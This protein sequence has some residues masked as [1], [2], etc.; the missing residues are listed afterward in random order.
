MEEGDP[1]I[2]DADGRGELQEAGEPPFV[3]G[4]D[5]VPF[6]LTMEDG[7]CGTFG[8]VDGDLSPL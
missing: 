5:A 8:G 3:H 2:V 7:C 1:L 4:V 6:S